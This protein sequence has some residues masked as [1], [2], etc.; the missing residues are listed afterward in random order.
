MLR[1]RRFAISTAMSVVPALPA[2]SVT[3]SVT[4]L[5]FASEPPGPEAVAAASSAS[6]RIE[7]FVDTSP[8]Y[9]ACSRARSLRVRAAAL[10]QPL[11]TTGG[12]RRVR[13]PDP[14]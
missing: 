3:V 4:G 10:D 1:L 11:R 6:T 13:A 14:R 8:L 5:G 7:A 2:S 9:P 12:G